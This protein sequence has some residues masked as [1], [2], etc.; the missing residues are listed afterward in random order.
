M[1]TDAEGALA[2]FAELIEASP[3]NLLS[4]AGL[5]ELRTRHIPESVEFAATLPAD[6]RLID[7]GS[8]GGLPGLVIAIVRPDLAVH[9]VETTGKKAAFLA[10]AAADLGL[11]VQISNARAEDLAKGDFRHAF[12]LVTA[13]ALARLDRLAVLAEPFLAPAGKILAIKGARWQEEL[14]EAGP[15]LARLRLEATSV[16]SAHPDGVTLR[17]LVVVLERRDPVPEGTDSQ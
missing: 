16:P 13:R 7:L 4:K 11:Q 5:L 10:A 12:D 17:P 14:D 2:R 3:H 8:G 15:T 6:K 1:G 9:L